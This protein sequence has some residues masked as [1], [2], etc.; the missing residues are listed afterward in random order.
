MAPE[1]SEQRMKLFFA[2]AAVYLVWGS[3]YLGI[4]Y[5]IETLPPF[6]MAG[7]R[8]V[9][10]GLALTTWAR[11]RGA[12]W[13]TGAQWRT[14]LVVGLGL[15]LGGNGGVVWAEQRVPSS[16]AALIVAA[17]PLSTVLLDWL[18][19]GG[20]RP[21]GT[22]MLGLAIGLFGVAVLVNPGAHDAARIDPWGALA[23]LGA[24]VS[25]AAGSIYSRR[26]PPGS[27]APSPLMGSGAYM[28][29]GGLGLLVAST[30]LGEPGRLQLGAVSLRS[31][32]ALLY[33][34]V[35][36]SLVGFT[37]YTW[38]LRNTTSAQATTYAYVNPVVAILIGW[39]IGG[40][41]LT[42]RT[43]VAAA[44]ILSGVITITTLPHL[45]AWLV[46]RGN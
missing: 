37:A 20:T 9:V 43:G 3:T 15:L 38:L 11:L 41:V 24:T 5:A 25:W 34:I 31:L 1:T 29:M 30:I 17:V 27:V 45:R 6:L 8:F 12:A 40:E 22:T 19:P 21:T 18:R 26:A 10:A 14:A 35:F 16:L 4:R 2:F 42:L 23:L 36:G 44:I 7:T 32:L 46:N 28:L 13:P 33:L 39:A